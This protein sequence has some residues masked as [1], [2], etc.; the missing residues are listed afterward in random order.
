MASLLK[1]VGPAALVALGC[2]WI[3]PVLRADEAMLPDGR[4]VHGTLALDGGSLWFLVAKPQQSLPLNQIEYVRFPTEKGTHF[5]IAAPFRLTLRDGEHWTGEFLGLEGDNVLFRTAWA[6]RLSLPRREV[7]AIGHA[8]GFVTV[9]QDDFEGSL[10]AWMLTSAPGLTEQ[11]HC[12]GKQSLRLDQ[13][14]QTAEYILAKSLAAGRV[15]INFTAAGDPSGARWQ[16]EA[17]FAGAR[18]HRFLQVVLAGEPGLYLATVASAPVGKLRQSPGWHRLILEFSIAS[19]ILSVDDD[20]LWSGRLEVGSLQKLRLTCVATTDGKRTGG[21]V[22]FDDFGLEQ[23]VKPLKHPQG[24]RG[25]D[26]LWLLSGDQLF[27]RVPGADRQ[28]IQLQGHLG[29]RAIKW[30]G[31]RGIY[32][33]EPSQV[34]S[35]PVAELVRLWLRSG[36]DSEGDRLHGVVKTL[37]QQQL[38][39]RHRLLGEVAIERHRLRR[40]Q[41]TVRA[42]PSSNP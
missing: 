2:G 28:A 14:G 24:D 36:I 13:A 22:C 29:K 30:A 3:G 40:L 11:E 35:K 15:G 39:L 23:A 1:I 27:G 41:A 33:R 17:E 21:A 34:P 20:L 5:R 32:F 25:Q 38:V 19:L 31:V 18:T 6:D 10:K 26:E 16:V 8:P 37:D 42:E 12:S 4:R 9:F 7:A